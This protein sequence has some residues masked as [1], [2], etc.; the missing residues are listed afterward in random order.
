M[1]SGVR[2]SGC[3]IPR[4]MM[5]RPCAASALARASTVKAFSSPMRSNA[6]MVF[7]IGSPLS[8]KFD[9]AGSLA[10]SSIACAALAR[11]ELQF[12]H[13]HHLENHRDRPA[14]QQQAVERGDW[15]GEPPSFPRHGV[16]VTQR[17]IV[18]E[19]KFESVDVFHLEAEP[20]EVAGPDADLN[21]VRAH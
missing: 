4:L 1:K 18:L 5:S 13:A 10:R 6:A 14:D 21:G 7:S 16:A 20:I 9:F 15:A 12:G 17:R 8:L 19:S 3:P 11:T 2:K